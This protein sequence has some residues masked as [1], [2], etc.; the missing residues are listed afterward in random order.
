MVRFV[1]VNQFTKSLRPSLG[2]NWA[3]AK[4]PVHSF[5]G[6]KGLGIWANQLIH[7]F[8]VGCLNP[9]LQGTSVRV[10]SLQLEFRHPTKERVYR[11][12]RPNRVNGMCIKRNDHA[13]KS[14]CVEIFTNIC[15]KRTVVR[16]S[17]LTVLLFSLIFCHDPFT[18][19]VKCPNCKY[20]H[21]STQSSSKYKIGP[22]LYRSSLNEMNSDIAPLANHS[23]SS[24]FGES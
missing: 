12:V 2:V 19:C 7:S 5:L 8:L 14:K 11:L 13:P 20:S 23:I 4:Q 18:V 21:K 24:S 6:G 3:G 15:P 1:F 9:C 16:N 17:S 10:V 22:P